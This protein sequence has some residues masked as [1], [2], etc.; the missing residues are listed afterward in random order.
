MTNKKRP[1]DSDLRLERN[2]L[3]ES[4]FRIN[5]KI[6]FSEWYS[7]DEN[8]LEVKLESNIGVH[9]EDSSVGRVTLK[10]EIFSEDYS[11]EEKPFYC[12][13][14]MQF[15]FRDS[16]GKYTESEN[17]VEKFGLSMISIAYPYIRAYVSTLSSISGID[18]IHIPT[19]NVFS[20]FNN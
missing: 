13:V 7:I 14:E 20:T 3:V 15:F 5:D 17:V 16:I 18:Q 8:D 12:K 6:N 11:N 4:I 10:V 9:A 19:I 1:V 2:I